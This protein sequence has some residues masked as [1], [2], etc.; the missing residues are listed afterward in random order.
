MTK[1][2]EYYFDFVSA[3]AF[4]SSHILPKIAD[5][6]GAELVY[7]PMF[8]GGVMKATGNVPPATV[9]PKGIWMAQDLQRFAKKYDLAYVFN[10]HFPVNTLAAMRGAVAIQGTDDFLPYVTAMTNAMWQEQANL[11][12][13]DVLA[14]IV[15]KLGMDPEAFLALT[16]KP[17]N[18][19]KLKA[20][21]D[22]AVAR[23]AFGAPSIF[24]GDEMYFGQ[25]RLF[26]VAEAVGVDIR[27][28]C[29]NY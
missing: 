25:D 21:T 24:V 20:N 22:E 1:T 16:Q 12:E 19:Q 28:I 15:A 27:D 13:P 26:M 18:K 14:A 4:F 3:T 8:L 5:A 29:P 23:G 7:K 10:P 6:A 17:E 2:I 11:A 9:I